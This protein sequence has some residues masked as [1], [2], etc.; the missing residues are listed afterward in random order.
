MKFLILVTL[1]LSQVAM[2]ELIKFETTST[3][4]FDDNE[5]NSL[6]SKEVECLDRAELRAKIREMKRL[7]QLPPKK[8]LPYIEES[9]C[10]EVNVLKD[11]PVSGFEGIRN[12]GLDYS[13][14]H[15]TKISG[16]Y[17]ATITVDENFPKRATLYP[18]EFK[19]LSAEVTGT[20]T[21][22]DQGS[23]QVKAEI[24]MEFA[25]TCESKD[26][27]GLVFY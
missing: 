25:G 19:V 27:A 20:G 10:E 2:A 15:N 7:V 8:L 21:I 16:V 23:Y 24:T 17:S 1:F 4:I 9:Q 18:K 13:C 14:Q 6:T 12:V 3:Q 26:D 11:R 5:A 22:I